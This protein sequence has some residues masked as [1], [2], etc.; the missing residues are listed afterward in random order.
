M[1]KLSPKAT[2][3]LM[4]HNEKMKAN[5]KEAKQMMMK[6]FTDHD[7]NKDGKLDFNEFNALCN[8]MK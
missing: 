2:F 8:T 3:E 7:S 4:A 5:P 6:M 1:Q